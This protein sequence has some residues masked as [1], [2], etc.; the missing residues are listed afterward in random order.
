VKLTEQEAKAR[1]IEREPTGPA[2]SKKIGVI[3]LPSFYAD[4]DKE[5]SG[6]QTGVSTTRH[7][8]MLLDKLK[9][10]NVDGIVLDLRKNGGGLLDEAV[11]LAGLFIEEGPVVQV[12]DYK[13]RI[14]VLE[15]EDPTVAYTG[16]LVVLT[17]HV[18]A[19]ASEIF[20]AAMQ[21]YGRG[22]V[23][24]D[25]KTFGKGTVQTMV[26]L[27]AWVFSD[28]KAGALKLTTQK[29]YRVAGGST[30]NRGVVPD[31]VLPSIYDAR[32]IGESA[33]DNALPYD[34]VSPAVFDRETV[35][36]Q[37][38]GEL[39]KRS[40]ARLSHDRDFA[41][42]K[43]D[44]ARLSARIKD[45]QVSLNLAKRQQ[46]KKADE[47]RAAAR[48]KERLARK[49]PE[50]KLTEIAL[51][52]V[53]RP[54]AGGASDKPSAAASTPAA[55]A[56]ADDEEEEKGPAVD[57]ALNEALAILGDLIDLV[58]AAGQVAVSKSAAT[59]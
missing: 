7:V 26:P 3:E 40:A 59:P 18:S 55:P 30:Q 36:Q 13:N 31:I 17:S 24:G 27:S 8:R 35:L 29:F 41:N 42:L 21:D 6:D 57:A 14:Q 48:K 56:G 53:P 45:G 33:L 9:A 54:A 19:S 44:I 23:A 34:E 39:K 46:E 16:P 15:D 58:S 20:A 5:R 47:D 25:S 32:E 12:K 50:P 28:G 52:P 43:D 38:L 37:H 2:R 10:Q 22:L 4:T 51:H 49:T 1:V 11:S